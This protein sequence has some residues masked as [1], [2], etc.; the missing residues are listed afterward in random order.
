MCYDESLDADL[1]K[2]EGA[3]V[4]E[5]SLNSVVNA[6]ELV[7]SRRVGSAGLQLNC[8]PS[9]LQAISRASK[10]IQGTFPLCSPGK[11]GTGCA[12]LFLP[13]TKL[14]WRDWHE[15]DLGRFVKQGWRGTA[16][17]RRRPRSTSSAVL[18]L[19]LQ[20]T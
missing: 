1:D 20:R 17:W 3:R 18:A 9:P 13:F 14:A 4:N 11:G 19:W 7:A 16:E 12:V 6:V 5:E 8:K 2:L 10:E 15:S